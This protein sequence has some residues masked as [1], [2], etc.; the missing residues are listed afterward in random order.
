MQLYRS[1]IH[2]G[3]SVSDTASE[4]RKMGGTKKAK[5]P[6]NHED[7]ETELGLQRRFGTKVDI[8]RKGSGGQIVIHFFIDDEM[9]GVLAKLG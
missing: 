7:R 9:K 5:T 4:T 1:I 2:S 3:M 8:R 6:L